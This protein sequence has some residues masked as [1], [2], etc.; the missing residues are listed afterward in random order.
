[1]SLAPAQMIVGR[2]VRPLPLALAL[3]LLGALWSGPFSP[4]APFG[5]A[6]ATFTGHMVIH[7][8]IVAG[9]APLLVLALPMLP[10]LV[11]RI[12][13]PLAA[14]PLA[15]VVEFAVV[16]GWH[17]P[18]MCGLA[19]RSGVAFAAEQASWLAVGILL[20]AA[21]LRPG[22]ARGHALW[23]GVLALLLTGMHMTLLGTLITLSQVPLYASPLRDQQVGGLIMLAVGALVYTGA[24]LALAH[25]G[26][27]PPTPRKESG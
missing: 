4:F 12:A 3:M 7:M 11:D 1:M 19:Q 20:W 15:A 5:G 22:A 25:R 2:R 21:V 9:V 14:A 18:A 26:L 23:A 16:W 8:G 13:P 24:G 17:T 27:E 10:A 6:P